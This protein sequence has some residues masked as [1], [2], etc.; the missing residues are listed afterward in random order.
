MSG[1]PAFPGVEGR[2]TVKLRLVNR[3]VRRL[4]AAAVSDAGVARA[5]IRAAG[6]VDRPER[7]LRPRVALR[8]LR[9]ALPGRCWAAAGVVSQRT[10]GLGAV[11]PG[12]RGLSR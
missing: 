1:D 10:A 4:H 3:Y 7:L 6:L 5:F 8:V 11:R 12:A 2:R 9:H